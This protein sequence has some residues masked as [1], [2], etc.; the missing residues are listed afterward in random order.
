MEKFNLNQWKEKE[1]LIQKLMDREEVLWQNPLLESTTSGLKKTKVS[2]SD[3]QDAAERLNRFAPYIE[4]VFPE[5]KDS[6]G[7]I[8]SLLTAIPNMKNTLAEHYKIQIPG[9]LYLKQDNALPISGSIKAR[10]GIYEI[11]KHAETLA[12]QNG[13]ITTDDNYAKFA[14]PEFTELFS[15]HK[16]AVGSTGNLG[17]K[18]RNYECKTRI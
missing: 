6:G 12:V 17:L 16:I 3:V 14:E 10:G 5:T 9:K 18:Y 11:L 7:I 8:E 13:L 1:P 2:V 4:R 15:R